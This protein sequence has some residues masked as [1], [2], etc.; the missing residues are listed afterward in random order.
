MQAPSLP[1]DTKPGTP[2][3][4]DGQEPPTGGV[5]M[6]GTGQLEDVRGKTR[7]AYITAY[8]GGMHC[9]EG[10]RSAVTTFTYQEPT[11]QV[12]AARRSASSHPE[13]SHLPRYCWEPAGWR[14]TWPKPVTSASVN[15]AG[16]L[17]KRKIFQ[18]VT[19]LLS[20]L[21]TPGDH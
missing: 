1:L 18:P 15:T 19:Q 17:T 13:P 20:R 5:P 11:V 2:S 6:R 10:F 9:G 12:Q 16:K 3:K 8:E 21:P 14:S 4:R 7:D